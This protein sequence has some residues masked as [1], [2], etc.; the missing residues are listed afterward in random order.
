MIPRD[1]EELSAYLDGQLGPA[2][3]A[4]MES[5]LQHEPDLESALGGLRSTRAV[6][7]GMVVRKAPRNFT[8][9][10]ALVRPRPPLPASYGLFRFSG[11]AAAALL[12]LTYV[13]NSLSA[14]PATMSAPAPFGMGGGAPEVL[15]EEATAPADLQAPMIAP[16]ATPLP[17][18]M[19]QMAPTPEQKAPAAERATGPE[20]GSAATS[21]I[22]IAWQVALALLTFGSIA[23]AL[24]IRYLAAARWRK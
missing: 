23:A 19:A 13:L 1:L 10:H 14:A 18:D 20:W 24:A 11:V 16:L 3:L 12:A 6:L 22:P 21:P 8:L 2:E 17:A 4:R 9:T 5:R 7:R 15:A